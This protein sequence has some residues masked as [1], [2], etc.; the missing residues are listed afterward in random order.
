M[1]NLH[2]MSEKPEFKPCLC[3]NKEIDSRAPK[4][5]PF[6]G[7]DIRCGKCFLLTPTFDT[8]EEL[9]AYWNSRPIE[10]ALKSRIKEL[11][12]QA[13][14]QEADST[15]SEMAYVKTIDRLNKVLKS[16]IKTSERS[17]IAERVFGWDDNLNKIKQALEKS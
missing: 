17:R 3:G 7:H 15:K 5:N 1:N 2:P 10:D 11:E 9:V 14:N 6:S 4:G 13:W 12:T 8:L 16:L